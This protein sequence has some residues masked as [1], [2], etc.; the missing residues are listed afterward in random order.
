M[1]FCHSSDGAAPTAG[2]VKGVDFPGGAWPGTEKGTAP[3]RTWAGRGSVE[4]SV[5]IGVGGV[6]SRRAW[7]FVGASRKDDEPCRA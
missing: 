5:I 4:M 1:K 2:G 7:T 6:A 3:A